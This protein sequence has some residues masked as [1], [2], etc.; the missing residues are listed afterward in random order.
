MARQHVGTGNRGSAQERVQ[1]SD[2]V[3]CDARHR[4]GITAAAVLEVKDCARTVVGTD[5]GEG[6]N[7]WEHRGLLRGRRETDGVPGVSV[8]AGAGLENHRGAAFA[9]ALQPEPATAPDVDETGEVTARC[10]GRDG[11]W[12]RLS[13]GWYRHAERQDEQSD[14]AAGEGGERA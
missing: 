11:G 3:A 14:E 5:P 9:A 1:V 10:G 4:H 6:R 2:D 7:A 13:H 12:R 8:I